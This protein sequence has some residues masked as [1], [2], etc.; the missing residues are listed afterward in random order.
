M[1]GKETPTLCH[2]NAY[3]IMASKKS[4]DGKKMVGSISKRFEMAMLYPGINDNY[5]TDLFYG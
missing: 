3:P 4:V 5:L 1:V 2:L